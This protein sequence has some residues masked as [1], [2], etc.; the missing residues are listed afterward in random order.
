MLTMVKI[1]LKILIKIMWLVLPITTKPIISKTQK[2]ENQKEEEDQ[3][4]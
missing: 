1:Q 3:M 4:P 2:K